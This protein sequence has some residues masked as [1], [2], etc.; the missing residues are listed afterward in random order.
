VLSSLL[1]RNSFIPERTEPLVDPLSENFFGKGIRTKM[2]TGEN[3]ASPGFCFERA[4]LLRGSE[5]LAL[6]T[7]KERLPRESAERRKHDR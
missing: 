3:R 4:F 5:N 6:Q 1:A 2:I 7:N